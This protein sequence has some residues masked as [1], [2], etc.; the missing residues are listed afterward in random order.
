MQNTPKTA[1]L[2]LFGLFYDDI[3]TTRTTPAHNPTPN[4]HPIVANSHSRRRPLTLD[5]YTPGRRPQAPPRSPQRPRGLVVF[6]TRNAIVVVAKRR[7][8]RSNARAAWLSSGRS[9]VGASPTRAPGVEAARRRSGRVG[10]AAARTRRRQGRRR[11][12]GRRRYRVAAAFGLSAAPAAPTP[13]LRPKRAPGR[14]RVTRLRACP[15]RYS[16]RV[17]SL[18]PSHSLGRARCPASTPG[19][20]GAPS[21][22]APCA[23][24]GRGFGSSRRRGSLRAPYAASPPSGPLAPPV[25]S[26]GPAGCRRACDRTLSDFILA[27]PLRFASLGAASASR[28]RHCTPATARIYRDV[29][30]GS[31]RAAP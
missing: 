6:R 1:F 11:G 3:N 22:V 17:P 18:R 25:R 7:L 20:G 9:G 13:A 29:R 23:G 15:R 8:A 4:R 27:W 19:L 12:G 26:F 30:P 10:V 21:P 28:A 5:S 2:P 24:G 31:T 14:L 16:R